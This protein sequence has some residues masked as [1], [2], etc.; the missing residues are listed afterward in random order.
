[1]IARYLFSEFQETRAKSHQLIDGILK[2]PE[3]YRIIIG[4]VNAIIDEYGVAIEMFC[5]KLVRAEMLCVTW[6]KRPVHLSLLPVP[7]PYH[8]SSSAWFHRQRAILY[9]GLEGR[10]ST[11][12]SLVH[13]QGKLSFTTKCQQG[14]T[15]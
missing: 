2:Y 15:I 10:V 1:M 3:W 8:L 5:I 13:L 7:S 12:L 11:Q 14:N 9:S 4:H 6:S